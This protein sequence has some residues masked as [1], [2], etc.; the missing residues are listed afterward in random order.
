MDQAIDYAAFELGAARPRLRDDL[1]FSLRHARHGPSYIIEDE[2]N[3]KFYRVGLAEYTFLSLL[4]GQRT[5]QTAVAATAAE[6]GHQ[7]FSENEAAALCKWLI[8]A[9]LADKRRHD[10][11][12]WQDNRTQKKLTARMQWINPIMLKIPLGNPDKVVTA[13]EPV[14][15][16]TVQ[17]DV[18]LDLVCRLRISRDASDLSRRRTLLRVDAD[19]RARQLVAVGLG[20]DG[21]ARGARSSSRVNV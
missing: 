7:A 10:H 14:D 20:L 9:G 15:D 8:D 2:T 4:D 21:P 1:R 5:V 11:D 3:S 12:R 13:V 17:L 6:L 19:S 16:A 18:R